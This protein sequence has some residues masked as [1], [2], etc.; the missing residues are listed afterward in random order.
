MYKEAYFKMMKVAAE[1]DRPMSQEEKINQFN[2]AG[3]PA[4]TKQLE[5]NKARPVKP[6]GSSDPRYGIHPHEYG[7]LKPF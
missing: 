3:Y 1:W 5:K 2:T 7:Y 6:S 4:V